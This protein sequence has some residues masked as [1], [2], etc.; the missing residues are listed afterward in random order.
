[1]NIIFSYILDP[2]R[3]KKDLAVYEM[4]TISNQALLDAFAVSQIF[5][6]NSQSN[7]SLVFSGELLG[8]VDSVLGAL[9]GFERG[10]KD[11]VRAISIEQL[12]SFEIIHKKGDI[13]FIDHYNNLKLYSYKYSMFKQ[14]F[15]KFYVNVIDDLARVYPDLITNIY[16]KKRMSTSGLPLFGKSQ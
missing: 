9:I 16:F 11:R 15:L 4:A 12:Y 3:I 8:F 13:Q 14:C 7:V 6:Y 1:M 2:A 5:I 10:D